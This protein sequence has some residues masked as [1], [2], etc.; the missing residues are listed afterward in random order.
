MSPFWRAEERDRSFHLSAKIG[1]FLEHA[2]AVLNSPGGAAALRGLLDPCHAHKEW[3]TFQKVLTDQAL[4]RLEFAA[5]IPKGDYLTLEVKGFVPVWWVLPVWLPELQ[6][7]LCF[8]GPV[9]ARVQAPC[10]IYP[11]LSSP[12]L[13]P[14]KQCCLRGPGV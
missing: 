1:N 8:F 9:P 4:E 10:R 14:V 11:V 12:N 6:R 7:R 3:S 13:L 2:D 5:F